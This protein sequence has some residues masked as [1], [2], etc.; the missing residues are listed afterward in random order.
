MALNFPTSPTNGQQYTDDNSVVWQYYATKGVWEKL[1]SDVLRQFSGAKIVFNS[2]K[3]L[4]STPSPCP[5]DVAEFDTGTYFDSVNNPTRLTVARSGYYRI[6]ILIAVGP[7]GN[8]AS[9]SFSVRRNGNSIITTEP[10]VG[11]NQ[12]VAYDEVLQLSSGEYIELFASE[13]SSIGTLLNSTYFEIERIGFGVGSAFSAGSEFSG[14]KLGLTTNESLTSTPNAIN[15]DTTEFNINADINANTYWSDVEASKIYIRSDGYYR[16]KAQ[17]FTNNQGTSDSYTIDV[18]KDGNS[19]VSTSLG[20]NDRLEL[21]ESYNLL[22]G[23]YFEIFVSNSSSV[24]EI[25]TNSYFQ[26][27]RMG[28]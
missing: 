25:T 1:R 21:D 18:R 12:F 24:G 5:F 10:L 2:T 6:N 17:F 4:T 3:F 19:F 15:W 22:S 7:E 27:I 28:V 26:L 13:E 9:Y 8:G 23:S 14:V 16:A 11:A 20:P